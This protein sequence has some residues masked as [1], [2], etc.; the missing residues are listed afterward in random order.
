MLTS[1]KFHDKITLVILRGD[2]M[3]R[4][5]I[6]SEKVMLEKT[7]DFINIKGIEALNARD[8]CDYIGC[9]TQPLFKN[10]IN[11]AGLKAK[12]R[13]FLHDYYDEFIDKIVDYDDYLYTISYAYALFAFQEPNIFKALFMSNLAG[14]RTI[15]EVLTSSWNTATIDSIPEQ[16]GLTKKQAQ[17][18]YRDVRFYTHG[19]SCQIACNSISVTDRE[20]Q[21]LIRDLI[22]RLKDVI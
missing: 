18:L 2:I 9:S 5:T 13:K 3:A 11:M 15:D 4:R 6:F 16:Y 19:L 20:I 1:F 14:T 7:C 12:L 22:L 17:Q 8:L 10:F 21:K